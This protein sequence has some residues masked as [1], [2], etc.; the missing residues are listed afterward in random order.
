MKTMVESNEVLH[1]Y[2]IKGQSKHKIAEECTSAPYGRKNR[3]GS[4]KRVCLDADGACDMEAFA[5]LIGSE[6]RFHTTGASVP[7]VTDEIKD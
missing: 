2:R 5:A 7:V 4:M 6:P 1:R 3:Y